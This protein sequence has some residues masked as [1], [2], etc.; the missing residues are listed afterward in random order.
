MKALREARDPVW[1]PKKEPADGSGDISPRFDGEGPLRY[2]DVVDRHHVQVYHFAYRMLQN[3]ADA[4]DVTQEVFLRALRSLPKLRRASSLKTWLFKI[5]TRLCI[6][7]WRAVRP[8][9]F[10]PIL[11]VENHGPAAALERNELQARLQEAIGRLHEKQR[12]TLVLRVFHQLTFREIAEVMGSPLGTVKANY[13]HA[14][15][16][17][18]SL[19]ENSPPPR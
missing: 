12:S 3:R 19:L 2:E 8:V 18:R 13:H 7:H 4:E 16:R 5:A 11:A 10:A 14:V 1:Q 9:S 17:L 15:S 6:D